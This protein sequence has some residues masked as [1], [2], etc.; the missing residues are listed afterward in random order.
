MSFSDCECAAFNIS[1]LSMYNYRT[2]CK[3]GIINCG[4]FIF[5]K[6]TMTNQKEPDQSS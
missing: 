6:A 5:Q 3:T 2:V 1:L 4:A